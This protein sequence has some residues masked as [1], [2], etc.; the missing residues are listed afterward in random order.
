MYSVKVANGGLLLMGGWFQRKFLY[1][2][3]AHTDPL[4]L[5]TGSGTTMSPPLAAP[6]ADAARGSGKA[7]ARLQRR[8]LTAVTGTTRRDSLDDLRSLLRSVVSLEAEVHR[9]R[10]A[11]GELMAQVSR[12][13]WRSSCNR[14]LRRRGLAALQRPRRRSSCASQRN[15]WAMRALRA[16]GVLPLRPLPSLTF[17]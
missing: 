17:S 15:S 10:Q 3:G 8:R 5:H 16:C 14:Q 4:A 7:L 12:A 6:V 2:L 11:E 1:R 9:H 13:L